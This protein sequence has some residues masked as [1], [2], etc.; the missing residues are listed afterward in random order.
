MAV[1]Y[2]LQSALLD[3]QLDEEHAWL[4]MAWK[5]PLAMAPV[6]AACAQVL[7]FI[8]QTGVRKVLNDNTLVTQSSWE[9]ARWVAENYLPRAAHLGIE[10]VAWVQSAD[11]FSRAYINTIEAAAGPLPQLALF[12]DV[13]S[14]YE[15]LRL[16]TIPLPS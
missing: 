6:Q 2:L 1:T 15:W 9:L 8:Q 5:G 10:S 3:V 16:P 14:A 12:E 7:G 11:I 13:A 4:Y